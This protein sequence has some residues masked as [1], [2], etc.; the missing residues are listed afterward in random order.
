MTTTT[1]YGGDASPLFLANAAQ[2]AS[3]H[4]SFE[5]T[6]DGTTSITLKNVAKYNSTFD[7]DTR[8]N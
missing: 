3:T 8:Y 5:F 2:V 7:F 4:Q 1:W 6:T